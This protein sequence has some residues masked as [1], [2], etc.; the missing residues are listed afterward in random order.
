MVQEMLVL[1]EFV[2]EQLSDGRVDEWNTPPPPVVTV[3]SGAGLDNQAD[4]GRNSVIQAVE[5]VPI[6]LSNGK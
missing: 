2:V 4:F 3:T 1:A 6:E 5:P